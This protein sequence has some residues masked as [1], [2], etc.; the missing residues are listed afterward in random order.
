MDNLSI[1]TGYSASSM[2]H[3]VK[4]DTG[5]TM[6]DWLMDMR[7]KGAKELLISTT[8]PITYIANK[9]GYKSVQGFIK[10]F[11]KKTGQTPNGFRLN[12]KER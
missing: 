10:A 4:E 1:K 7:I 3:Y 8:F 9:V 6:G 12:N 11:K 2:Y 5:K